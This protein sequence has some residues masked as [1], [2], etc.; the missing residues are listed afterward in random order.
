MYFLKK[1]QIVYLK[2]DEAIYKILSKYADFTDVFSQ[3]LALELFEYTKS[4]IIL[5]NE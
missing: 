5:S 3:K 2:A 1:A 4:T